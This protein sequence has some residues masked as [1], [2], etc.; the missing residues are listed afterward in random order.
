[1]RV[2]GF[3]KGK[4]GHLSVSKIRSYLLRRFQSLEPHEIYNL[5]V[6][7]FWYIHTHRKEQCLQTLNPMRVIR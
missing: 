6:L 7:V 5:Y 4:V 3:A 2:D 1:M